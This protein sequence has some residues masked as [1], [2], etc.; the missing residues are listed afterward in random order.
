MDA[1][2]NKPCGRGHH[3]RRKKNFRAR[4]ARRKNDQHLRQQVNK[5]NVIR[6]RAQSF[7]TPDNCLSLPCHWQKLSDTQFCKVEE[8]SSGLGEVTA[9][10]VLDSNRTCNVYIGHTKVPADCDILSRFLS[11]L[12]ASELSD[13]IRCVEN[14]VLCPV[15]PDENFVSVCKAKGGVAKGE[16]GHGDVVAFIDNSP[17]TDHSGKQYQCTVR[18]ADYEVLCEK[19][20][21]H[22]LRC[23]SC[24]SFRASLRSLV[25]C[26]SKEVTTHQQTV[27]PDTVISLLLRRTRE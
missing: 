22:P 26:Q 25:H 23:K 16:R 1:T 17:F 4:F 19:S 8:G 5:E 7:I 11:Y 10:V 18:R 14:A 24:Q 13:L 15:N 3:K 27:I 2:S 6:V 12:P 21:R 20:S 9:S